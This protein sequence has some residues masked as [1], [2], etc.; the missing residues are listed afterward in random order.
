MTYL[1]ELIEIP[2]NDGIIR[3]R[4]EDV[5]T[6]PPSPCLFLFPSYLSLVRLTRLSVV[7]AKEC[8]TAEDYILR[9]YPTAGITVHVIMKDTL[10][11]DILTPRSKRGRRDRRSISQYIITPLR[12]KRP[13]KAHKG[14]LNRS[15]AGSKNLVSSSSGITIEIHEDMNLIFHDLLRE[16]IR[17]PVA[18][19]SENRSFTL[20]LLSVT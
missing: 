2:E 19:V 3:E 16:P 6:H 18:D 8:I 7:A 12:P 20:D 4:R 10:K 11:C 1:V 17:R 15:R 9:V 5:S 14:H 13:C